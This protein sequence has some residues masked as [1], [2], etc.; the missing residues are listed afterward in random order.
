MCYRAQNVTTLQSK[1]TAMKNSVPLIWNRKPS[2]NRG[3]KERIP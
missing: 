3:N 2:Q 1:P